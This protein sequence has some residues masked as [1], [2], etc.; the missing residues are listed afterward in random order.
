VKQPLPSNETDR[1]NALQRY[2]IL[3][4]PPEQAFDDLTRLAA[5]ICQTPTALISLVDADRQWFKSKVGLTVPETPRDVAFCAHTIEARHLLIVPDAC[6][7]D[8]FANNPLV[9][10]NPKIRFYVGAPLITPDNFALGTL[11]AIDYV[12]RQLSPQQQEALEILARQVVTQLELRRNLV[13]LQQAHQQQQQ[14]ELALRESRERYRDL[15]ENA[16]DLIQSVTP[17]GRFIYVNRAWKETLGY[18]EAE[19]VELKIYDIIHSDSLVHCL[20]VFGQVMAGEKFAQVETIFVTKQGEKIWVEGSINCQFVESKPMATRG[21]FRNISDRKAAEL[22]LQNAYAHLETKVAERTAALVSINQQL[23]NEIVE[24][25]R[26]EE[27]V[28]L[29]QKITQAIGDSQNF[30]AAL[31]VALRQICEFTGWIYGE[32]W[33]PWGDDTLQLSPAWYGKQYNVES[34]RSSSKKFKFSPGVGLIGRVW[35]SRQA[36]WI[37]SL[38]DETEIG[39]V[40]SHLARAAGL[41]ACLA[42]PIIADRAADKPEVLAAIAFFMSESCAEDKRQ[43]EIVSTVAAQLG[44]LMQRKRA[45]EALRD[46]EARYRAVVKQTAEGIF[47]VDIATKRILEANDAFARFLGYSPTQLLQLTLYDIFACD[48]LTIDR[49]AQRALRGKNLFLGKVPHHRSNGSV[50]YAEVYVTAIFYGGKEVFCAIAHDVTERQQVQEALRQSEER[51]Q[52]ILDNST[53]LIYV[54]DLEG[55]YLT[56]NAWYGILFHLD[57]TEAIG[58]TD[59]EIFPPEIADV[60]RTN[61]RQVL[62]TKTALN[63]EEVLPHDDGL[64]TYLSVKFPLFDAAG[65]PYAVGGI[66]TDITERKRAEEALRSSLATNRALINA[67]PDLIFRFSCDGTFIN[68]KASKAEELLVTP[69]QFLGKRVDEVMPP[70]VARPT[71]YYI[72]QA[73]TTGELQIFEYQLDI[74]DKLQDYEARLVVSAENEVMAIVRNITDRKRAEAEIHHMLAK[75]KELSELKSRFVTMTSHEFRTPLT[76]ILSSAELMEDF[77]SQ[78]SEEKKLLHLRRI[79]TTVKHMNQLLDDVLLIGKAEAGKLEC[80]PTALDLVQFCRHLVEEMQ[81][82]ADSHTIE[83]NYECESSQAILDEKLLRHILI[84]LLSNAIKYSPAGSTVSFVLSREAEKVIFRIQDRGIGIPKP[85]RE[86]LF[87][88]FYRASNVGTISGTGLGLAIVKRALD[89]HQ[90]AIALDSEVGVGTT[91]VVSLP[92]QRS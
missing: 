81:M 50:A 65:E 61:D 66:S 86:Q 51:L 75:E 85:D 80:N 68:Y 38:E 46:S 77:G 69:N 36:R 62:E 32:A 41:K 43:V 39:I 27:E 88:S 19:L 30:H 23:G 79:V 87:Q 45:E 25:H 34:F 9:T 24:R 53:A 55:K 3:D 14:T 58:K 59:Y 8:R 83:F 16:S 20:E 28:R 76:T 48:R 71:M 82:I 47:L 40:R 29:L 21:I 13:I 2:G 42:I 57:R 74:E 64:H 6:Q 26:A 4:T 12:P 22:A 56:L 70:E 35:L 78:W 37:P 17:D 89:L 54:K 44:A 11:C 52:A 31:G 60:L 5:Q 15:F 91:F 67:I 33:I 72:Q 18:S 73:L 84:N 92:Y 1:L 90:G 10:E 7:D 49:N 63:W